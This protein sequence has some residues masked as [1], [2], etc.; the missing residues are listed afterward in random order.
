MAPQACKVISPHAHEISGWKILS[1][2]LPLRAPHIEGMN[3][4][5]QSDLAILEFNNGE[6]LEV[7][8]S[9]IIR[10]QQEIILYRETLYPTIFIFQH[11]KALSKSK[12]SKAFIA[13][14]MTDLITFLDNNGKCA[15]YTGVNIH[16]LYCYIYMVGAPTTLTTSGQRYHD[17]FP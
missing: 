1:R 17:F 10:L 15:V 3:G 16:G 11:M 12:K 9:R 5:V 8:H 14:K 13:P 4:G 2:L 7:F 6:K